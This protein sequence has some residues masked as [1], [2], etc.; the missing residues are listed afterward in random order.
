M[1]DCTCWGR[2]DVASWSEIGTQQ[3]WTTAYERVTEQSYITHQYL[4]IT[5]SYRKPKHQLRKWKAGLMNEWSSNAYE[6]PQL[7][8]QN[9]LWQ[10]NNVAEDV[11]S[12]VS[13]ICS[14]FKVP[15]W[16]NMKTSNLSWHAQSTS[17]SGLKPLKTG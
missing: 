1:P 10:R 3:T 12:F 14:S 17:C 2:R 6:D 15:R 7:D 4:S 8:V 13:S 11:L 9:F 5:A 16:C